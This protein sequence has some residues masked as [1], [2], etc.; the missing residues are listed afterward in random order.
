[1][2]VWEVLKNT[3]YI[4]ENQNKGSHLFEQFRIEMTP[5]ASRTS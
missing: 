1:V 2:D 5:I 4:R 3:L